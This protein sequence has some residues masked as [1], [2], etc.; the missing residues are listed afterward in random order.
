MTKNHKLFLTIWSK[1]FPDN[2]SEN[3]ENLFTLKISEPYGMEESEEI[4]NKNVKL[5]ENKGLVGKAGEISPMDLCLLVP[6]SQYFMIL[7]LF[8]I[9]LI[10]YC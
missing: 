4:M 3:A 8:L 7:S 6:S 9:Y 5:E 10:G 2:L 1:L